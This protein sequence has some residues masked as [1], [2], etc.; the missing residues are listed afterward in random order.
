MKDSTL[1]HFPTS[2]S[3]SNKNLFVKCLIKKQD[4]TRSNVPHTQVL[5]LKL[6]KAKFGIVH[7]KRK[8]IHLGLVYMSRRAKPF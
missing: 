5:E 8:T 2:Q 1:G 4:Y 6:G 7:F 3:F